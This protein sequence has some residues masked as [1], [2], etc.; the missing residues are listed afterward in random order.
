MKR[1]IKEYILITIGVMLLGAGVYYF[2]SPSNLAAGGVSGLAMVINKFLPGISLS[3]LM[4]IMNVALFIIGFALIG[5]NFGAKSIYATI[6]LSVSIWLYE[7]VYPVNGPILDDLLIVLIFGILISGVG[8][9]IVFNQNASTG[10]TD[11]I[12]KIINKYFHVDIGKSLFIADFL[13]TFAA[14]MV[15]GIRTGMYALLGVFMNSIVI[16]SFI[17]GYNMCMQMTIIS[18]QGEK[19]KN[20]IIHDLSRGV[21]LY[22][23]RGAFTGDSK[24]VIMTVVSRREFIK[25]KQFIADNDKNAFIT[26]GSVHEVLGEGFGEI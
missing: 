22:E 14:G 12:A 15:F 1:I 18:D 24:E 25:I 13:I 8:M 16:D 5:S 7:K 20:Y 11:I 26:V 9:A 6:A 21:T 17:Q 23:A 3:V 19:I 4:L 10:G 2:L